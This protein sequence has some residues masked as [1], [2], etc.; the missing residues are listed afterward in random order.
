[1]TGMSKKI[2]TSLY[3]VNTTWRSGVSNSKLEETKCLLCDRSFEYLN[4]SWSMAS[5]NNLWST[6]KRRKV[7][8]IYYLFYCVTAKGGV[9]LNFKMKFWM[10]KRKNVN[11]MGTSLANIWSKFG[12]QLPWTTSSPPVKEDFHVWSNTGFIRYGAV[13]CRIVSWKELMAYNVTTSLKSGPYS[14][15]LFPRHL[16]STVHRRR[17]CHIYYLFWGGPRKGVG[18]VEL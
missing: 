4:Q 5:T 3:L 6:L 15:F 16:C 1:M 8:P 12:K 14:M 11:E 18:E 2:S 17:L 13:V 7:C 10:V 9:R